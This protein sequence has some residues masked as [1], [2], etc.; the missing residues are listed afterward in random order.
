MIAY[1]GTGHFVSKAAARNNGYSSSLDDA[2]KEGRIVIGNP[3]IKAGQTLIIK[4]D[5][6]YIGAQA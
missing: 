4:N 2:L 6:Y 5:Q 3:E 1:S